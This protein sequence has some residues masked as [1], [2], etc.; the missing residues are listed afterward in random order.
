MSSIVSY[1]QATD[2][3][4]L[5][6]IQKKRVYKVLAITL[7]SPDSELYFLQIYKIHI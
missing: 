2:L 1:R 4:L 6:N 7:Q 3:K 5:S